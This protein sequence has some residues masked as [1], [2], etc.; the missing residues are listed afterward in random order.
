[1]HT[2]LVLEDDREINRT[3]CLALEGEGYRA[4]PAHC[5]A[6]A[7]EWVRGHTLDLAILDVSLPDGDGFSFCRTLLSRR[8]CAVLF[9]SARDL[10]EDVLRGYEQGAADY[11]TK[12]FSLKVLLRKI[13]LL[14]GGGAPAAR[15]Y[16]DGYLQIDFELGRVQCG[17]RECPVTPTEYRILKKLVENRGRLLTYGVLLDALWEEG[18]Q[19]MDKH[20]LAVHINRLRKKIEDGEHSCISNVYG[21]GYIWK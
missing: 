17:A 18:V 10:E 8:A 16:D 4:V 21:M 5:C 6:Q 15:R 1:M 2:I 14:L 13:A 11:V 9:L 7:E 19:L 20:A 12:P 3:L